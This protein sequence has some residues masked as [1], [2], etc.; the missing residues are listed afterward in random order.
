MDITLLIHVGL[1]EKEI[2]W[3]AESDELPGVT[4]AAP[5]LMQMREEL[6]QV[7]TDLSAEQGDEIVIGQ[8]MLAPAEGD[9]SELA[10]ATIGQDIEGELP[11]SGPLAESRGILV[12]IA[13]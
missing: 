5:T 7:L 3:W 12:P 1:A 4:V 2:V 11:S 10:P 9:A 6:D 13:A 8:E